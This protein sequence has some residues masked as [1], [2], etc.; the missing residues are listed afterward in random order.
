M[1]NEHKLEYASKTGEESKN[2]NPKQQTLTKLF[3][4]KDVSPLS[5]IKKR[6][7][8]LSLED[9]IIDSLRPLSTVE[10]ASFKKLLQTL[11]PKY[12]P[13]C[14]KT[15]VASLSKRYETVASDLRNQLAEC[16]DVS[17]THDLWSSL[18]TEAFGATTVH[19]INKNWELVSKVLGTKI[20]EGQHTAEAISGSLTKIMEEWNIDT[21]GV[22]GVTD[23]AANECKAFDI[24]GWNRL[25]CSGHNLNLAVSSALK[26]TEVSK[27]LRRGSSIVAYLHR[28]SLATGILYE[29]QKLLLPPECHGHKLITDVATR[30]NSTFDMPERLGEQVPSLHATVHDPSLA[31]QANDLKS[32]LFSY[33]ERLVDQII[34]SC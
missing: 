5:Q 28:S 30:W 20:F 10:Q 6:Q 32:K 2:T 17:C 25:S 22:I 33:D 31:K 24:L 26:I 7:I 8:D 1:K 19:F 3:Q 18:N 12:T 23:N 11:E 14:R 16:L 21:K 13:P 29:K 27:I 9:Y 15:L 34:F 4:T